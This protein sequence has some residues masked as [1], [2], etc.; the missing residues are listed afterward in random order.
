ME[1]RGRK[2]KFLT[3]TFLLGLVGAAGIAII[4]HLWKINHVLKVVKDCKCVCYE[5]I[6]LLITYLIC[7]GSNPTKITIQMILFHELMH[8][9]N[10]Y[11]FCS[12]TGLLYINITS[13]YNKVDQFP[14]YVV[15]T[16]AFYQSSYVFHSV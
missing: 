12:I 5:A 10:F 2:A 1:R 9:L 16:K 14:Q 11:N 7:L 15:L 8:L 13:Y 6:Q 4:T 3:E